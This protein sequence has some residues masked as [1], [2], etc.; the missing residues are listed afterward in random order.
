M[1]TQAQ[2]NLKGIADNANF[3]KTNDPNYRF[4]NFFNLKESE[5]Y[6]IGAIN[7]T[8]KINFASSMTIPGNQSLESCKLNATN[9]YNQIN[10]I[11]YSSA[12]NYKKNTLEKTMVVG[13][14]DNQ[15]LLNVDY[16]LDENTETTDY[17]LQ[18]L[19]PELEDKTADYSMSIELFGYIVA[20]VSGNY[21][22]NIKPEYLNSL[23][24]VLAW[25]KNNAESSYRTTNT[26]FNSKEKQNT[27]IYLAKGVFIPIRI[28]MIAVA[29]IGGFPF[30]ISDGKNIVSDYYSILGDK[31]KK[32]VV[33]ALTTVP[34]GAQSCK[35]YTE[36]NIEDYGIDKALWETGKETKN[37]EIKEANRWNLDPT[38]D[39]VGLD[40][41]GNL[42]AFAGSVKVGAP[43]IASGFSPANPNSKSIYQMVLRDNVSDMIR[44][45]RNNQFPNKNTTNISTSKV[46]VSV[47]G[48][49]RNA[50]WNQFNNNTLNSSD[51]IT[52]SDPLVSAK[53]LFML[54]LVKNTQ[55]ASLVLYAS[56]SSATVFYGINVD[57]KLGKTFY[58]NKN[59][60]KEYL[61]EVPSDLT[62]Y[63]STSQYATYSEYYPQL[64][65]TYT[66]GK[67][68]DCRAECN[69]DPNCTHTY[70][71]KDTTGNTQ[72][73]LSSEP[74]M[75]APK[76]TDS[77]YTG[78][79][80]FVRGKTLDNTKMADKSFQNIK[81]DMGSI[82]GFNNYTVNLPLTKD[83]LAGTKGEPEYIQL[84][85]KISAS[86]SKQIPLVKRDPNNKSVG[87][88]EGF[89]GLFHSN[90]EGFQYNVLPS[91]SSNTLVQNIS[92][93]LIGLQGQIQDYTGIQ[94]R[95]ANLARDISGNV[96]NINT[97]YSE[98]AGNDKYD[99]TTTTNIKALDEDYSLTP[100]LLKDNAIFL[101]EQNNL[102]IVGTITLATLLISAIFISR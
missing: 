61:R 90:L 44:L 57:N 19:S 98:M 15:G 54:I 20:P 85:N 7:D 89:G 70:N 97:K 94:T 11:D 6:Q 71:V 88:V 23:D 99:F 62:A 10:T 63:S 78:S 68:K 12:S 25:L 21:N 16:F 13:R 41:N 53:K 40:E 72:C 58:A 46:S 79:T 28:Q 59:A 47:T 30:V 52:E 83:S 81:Y 92:G 22:L 35:V 80:L 102:N 87:A 91:G 17:D 56:T 26:T 101:E 100:A 42:V 65:G 5:S 55:S 14:M 74:V 84:Q 37:I 29:P 50:G 48:L 8:N 77:Q 49:S 76:S 18:T 66:V 33:F 38:T 75:Y 96:D 51:K 86:T 4:V 43:I 64:N 82:A 36:G 27:S 32:Q 60:A 67:T 2:I 31:R 24:V 95:V 9:L 1:A 39:S 34:G 45:V 93:Q 3:A 73:L 69:T